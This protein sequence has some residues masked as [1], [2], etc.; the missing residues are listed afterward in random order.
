MLKDLAISDLGR[1]HADIAIDLGS[2]N[3]RIGVRGR[4][5]VAELPSVVA[6]EV[7][8]QTR[9]IVAVGD[10][11]RQMLG[12]TPE[13]IR[14]MRPIRGSLIEDY[15]LVQE[16]LE[17]AVRT[18]FHG[19]APSRSR[20]AITLGHGT[21][22]VARRAVQDAARAV[23]AREVVLIPKGVAAAVGSGL[24]V[25]EAEGSLLLD[26]GGGTTE[27]VLMSLGGLI[28][29]EVISVGGMD[30]DRAIAA[31]MRSALGVSVGERAAEAL[32][33]KVAGGSAS[34]S[35]S[36]VVTGRDER[37]GIPKEVRVDTNALAQA[38]LPAMQTVIHGLRTVLARTTP[39]LSA[40]IA[41]NG[42]VLAG[43]GALM[44]GL[45]DLVRDASGLPVVL[46]EAPQRATVMG[47]LQLL[48][49]PDALARVAWR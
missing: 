2:T 12:R 26:L 49:D 17:H 7:R 40:D 4:G 46:S 48:E 41:D 9:N 24:P 16:L 21:E 35:A 27:I 3:T 23:G 18:A 28:D 38:V 45:L 37:T 33:L 47:A 42:L 20:V 10:D 31:W 25:H 6:V 22:E 34:A 32:K 30:I 36:V 5:L 19:R 8:G 29:H 15:G 13:H 11:A 39:E 14:A 1:R 43:G 44:P